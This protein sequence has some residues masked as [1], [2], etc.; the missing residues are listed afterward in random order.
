MPGDR[1]APLRKHVIAA[2]TFSSL[3]VGGFLLFVTL[4]FVLNAAFGH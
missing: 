2:I 3:L 1:D 4:L